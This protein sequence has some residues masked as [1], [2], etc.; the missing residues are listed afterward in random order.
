LKKY[1]LRVLV[2]GTRLAGIDGAVL[3]HNLIKENPAIKGF[4]ITLASRE[5]VIPMVRVPPKPDSPP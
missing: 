5:G 1:G 2:L 4:K 3:I